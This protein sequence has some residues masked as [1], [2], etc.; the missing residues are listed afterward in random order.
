MEQKNQTVIDF[1]DFLKSRVYDTG[2]FK[3]STTPTLFKKT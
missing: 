1:Y 2:K 3:K